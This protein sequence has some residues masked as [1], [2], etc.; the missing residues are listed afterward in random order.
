MAVELPLVIIIS[1]VIIV[2]IL[3]AAVFGVFQLSLSDYTD[4]EDWDEILFYAILA[5]LALVALSFLNLGIS[6]GPISV[7]LNM[8]GVII[9]IGIVVFLM[10]TKRMDLG[11]AMISIGLVAVVAFPLTQVYEGAAYIQFPF[12]LIP[13]AVGAGCGFFFTRNK[14]PETILIRGGAIAYS[15]GCLG[16]LLGGDILHL[17]EILATGGSNLVLG[18]GGILDFVFLTGVMALSIV[19][20]IQG[21]VPLIKRYLNSKIE[22]DTL[23]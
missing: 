7:S 19:W 17:P 13:A 12:W 9:P 4:R 15:A 18:A 3:L 14:D 16:M 10:V 8:T 1:A 21:A 2:L 6:D 11:A 22:S 5:V 23:S 20:G